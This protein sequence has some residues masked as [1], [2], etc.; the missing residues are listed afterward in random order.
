MFFNF[1]GIF[2]EYNGGWRIEVKNNDDEWLT[3]L[4]LIGDAIIFLNLSSAEDYIKR[5]LKPEL[6]TRLVHVTF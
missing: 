3:H 1:K 2:G 4:N 5:N 6:E